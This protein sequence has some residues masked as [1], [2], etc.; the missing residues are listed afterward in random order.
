MTNTDNPIKLMPFHIQLLRIT[1]KILAYLTLS[2]L[3]QHFLGRKEYDNIFFIVQKLAAEIPLLY[4]CLLISLLFI[5]FP[6][7]MG[8]YFAQWNDFMYASSVVTYAMSGTTIA[9]ISTNLVDRL[10][11]SRISGIFVFFIVV[12]RTIMFSDYLIRNLKYK[13]ESRVK[14]VSFWAYLGF[15]LHL[16]SFNYN[17]M[18]HMVL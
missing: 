17:I 10:F 14:H 4:T 18:Y 7:L 1:I 15:L 16:R 5:M 11:S 8:A 6:V 3:I 13:N 9:L 2:F 12:V